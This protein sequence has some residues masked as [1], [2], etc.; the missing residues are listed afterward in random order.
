MVAYAVTAKAPPDGYT[1]V[2]AGDALTIS[3]AGG[4]AT[5]ISAPK[6][7]QNRSERHMPQAS[8]CASALSTRSPGRTFMVIF[9]EKTLIPLS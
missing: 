1:L 7:S 5:G 8:C 6:C 4:T 3:M 9:A 2:F